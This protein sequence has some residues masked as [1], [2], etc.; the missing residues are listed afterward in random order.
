MFRECKAQRRLAKNLWERIHS[1]KVDQALKVCR[2][3]DDLANEFAPTGMGSPE[4]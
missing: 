4:K 3:H 2:L 1:R